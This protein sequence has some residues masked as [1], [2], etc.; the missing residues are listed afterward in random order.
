MAGVLTN[1]DLEIASVV[2][3][4]S[5]TFHNSGTLCVLINPGDFTMYS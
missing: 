1:L 2:K 3:L 5:L 4:I